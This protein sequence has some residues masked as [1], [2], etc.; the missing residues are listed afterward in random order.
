M[1]FF[2]CESD[3]DNSYFDI[4]NLNWLILTIDKEERTEDSQK[5]NR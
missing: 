1:Y 3:I 2:S 5:D 4:Q